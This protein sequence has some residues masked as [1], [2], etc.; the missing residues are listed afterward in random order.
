MQA[1]PT[2]SMFDAFFL[3]VSMMMVLLSASREGVMKS[4]WQWES[5]KLHFPKFWLSMNMNIPLCL[6]LF[7]SY[8]N[9]SLTRV[10]LRNPTV[11]NIPSD[12]SRFCC[13]FHQQV[14]TNKIH[15][16]QPFLESHRRSRSHAQW[17]I[18]ARIEAGFG[19]AA[20]FSNLYCKFFKQCTWKWQQK[21]WS[22][23]LT[24]FSGWESIQ[25]SDTW[26]ESFSSRR[27]GFAP[28]AEWAVVL[29]LLR[30]PQHEGYVTVV[31]GLVPRI[32]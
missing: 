30:F 15:T 6:P 20:V 25:H 19:K 24:F 28:S 17:I 4:T 26:W 5:I 22:F 7:P 12:N 13:H 2:S 14:P 29:L 8:F 3:R 10:C 9:C 31:N 18:P 11:D 27:R 16:K 1:Y 21:N 23:H 32:Q